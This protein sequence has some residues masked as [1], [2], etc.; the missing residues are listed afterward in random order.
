[1]TV[2]NPTIFIVDDDPD[3]RRSLRFLVESV[4]L[5][6]KTYESP[7]EFLEA[8]DRDTPGCLVLDLLMPEMT[9]IELLEMLRARGV[10]IPV[11]MI[12]AFGEVRTAVRAMKSGAEIFLTK[13]FDTEE[14]M[15]HVRR[16]IDD[17]V[18]N[19]ADAKRNN[20]IRARF[21]N[22]SRRERQVFELLV[23]GHS[24]KSIGKELSITSKTVEFH[25]ANLMRKIEAA[26]LAHLVNMAPI[27]GLLGISIGDTGTTTS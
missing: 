9:G 12:T 2:T 26:S 13:P 8:F 27:C 3:M 22:L 19:R 24:N 5:P 16:C 20:E 21:A 18:R 1:M 7:K 11:V 4:D 15:A 10:E 23:E 6:V 17:D 25:R 14:L